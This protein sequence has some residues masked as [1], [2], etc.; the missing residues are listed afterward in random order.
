MLILMSVDIT[1]GIMSIFRVKSDTRG[2]SL[3]HHDSHAEV[4]EL[5]T[6]AEGAEEEPAGRQETPEHN[7]HPA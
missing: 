5:Q 4:E 3:T 1:C 2:F 6:V 7:R